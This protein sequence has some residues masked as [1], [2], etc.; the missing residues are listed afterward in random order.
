MPIHGTASA[1]FANTTGY[2]QESYPAT[3]DTF[4]TLRVRVVALPTGAPRIFMLSNA[5]VT[6]GNLTLS[7]TG[8]LRLRNGSTAVGAESMALQAGSTY[9]IGLHQTRGTG[10]NAVLEA[11]VV[12]DGA[13]FGTPFARL[14]TGTWTT[15]ADRFRLGATNGTAVN[16]TVDDVL[17]S[18][19]S[20]PTPVAIAGSAI[21]A[22]AAPG[23]S[24]PVAITASWFG[25]RRP[26]FGVQFVCPI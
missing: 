16:L 5:G 23:S 25:V 1:R 22:A 9:R 12:A 8:R 2:L 13:T 4:L 15:S 26:A 24:Y 18:S 20:M 6:T 11:W 10:G 14:T 7:S 21:L 17:I 19:G 3:A